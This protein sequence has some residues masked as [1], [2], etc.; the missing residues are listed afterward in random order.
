MNDYMKDE[1]LDSENDV[2]EARPEAEEKTQNLTSNSDNQEKTTTE[3]KDSSKPEQNKNEKQKKSD[4]VVKSVPSKKPLSKKAKRAIFAGS[5]L[6]CLAILAVLLLDVWIGLANGYYGRLNFVEKPYSIIIFDSDNSEISIPSEYLGMDVENICGDNL[7][8]NLET[9]IIPEGVKSISSR[10]FK[11]FS[12]LTTVSFPDSLEIIEANAFEECKR[13]EK[14][15]L[16][17][18]IIIDDYAFLN[19]TSLKEIIIRPSEKDE[20]AAAIIGYGSFE[21]C[22]SLESIDAQSPIS[23]VGVS[24]FASCEKLMSVSFPEG[25][26]SIDSLAF[27]N[28]G[29]LEIVSIPNSVKYVSSSGFSGCDNL[30]YNYPSSLNYYWSKGTLYLG[31]EDNPFLVLMQ[32]NQ[33][34]FMKPLHIT[35]HEDTEVIAT[36]AFYGND[37]L[38]KVNLPNS[39]R[40]IGGSAFSG[41]ESLMSITIPD[42]VEIIGDV[43]FYNCTS[44][45]SITLGSSISYIGEDAFEFCRRIETV[46]IPS[47]EDWLEIE[48]AS[49]ESNPLVYSSQSIIP[50]LIADNSLVETIS[51]PESI[52]KINDYA[53]CGYK[54]I[55]GVSIHE[56]VVSIGTGSFKDC[57]N[58][59]VFEMSDGVKTIG[60]EAFMGC[61]FLGIFNMPET[62]ESVGT[63]AFSGLA[64]LNEYENGCYIG[65]DDNPYLILVTA[66]DKRITNCNIHQ[67]TRIVCDAFTDCSHLESVVIPDS[68]IYI[69]WK[70][71]FKKCS[72]L[73]T[74]HIGSGITEIGNNAFSSAR[75]L[76]DVYLTNSI[77]KFDT[78]SFYECKKLKNIY[79][80]GGMSEWTEIERSYMD[81]DSYSSFILYTSEFPD[82][83]DSS[84]VL[85]M[86]VLELFFQLING[87]STTILSV[88]ITLGILV[89]MIILVCLI[90]KKKESDLKKRLNR[91][92][93][94]NNTNVSFKSKTNVK[95]WWCECG[96]SNPDSLSTCQAC[97]KKRM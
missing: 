53:F 86:S 75:A 93:A 56:N 26:I 87:D 37:V 44:L 45:S 34:N 96:C 5:L 72:A 76:E 20:Q 14:I 21:G 17:A 71:C 23:S 81:I 80:D 6:A 62:I 13:L 95:V 94:G 15:E 79:F 85:I 48:F 46:N 52:N 69:D 64:M 33:L 42:S 58:L 73:K 54:L 60:E 8:H 91:I 3:E 68:V 12:N 1:R 66:K 65:N 38:E 84:N 55:A 57:I 35:V 77:T 82:G 28:C 11:G 89:I 88:S 61:K 18:G 22:S 19:C 30:S 10:T 39:L 24:A 47:I 74:I 25:L 9:L 40:V 41:C 32:V 97:F 63:S 92:D 50:V 31:N 67:N 29:S 59:L 43:A 2:T 16:P 83:I 70:N 49:E 78:L 4:K 90:K 7:N 51:V 27:E 36:G